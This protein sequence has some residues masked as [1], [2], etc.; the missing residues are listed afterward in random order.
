MKSLGVI[1]SSKRKLR[2]YKYLARS[3]S[4]DDDDDENMEMLADYLKLQDPTHGDPFY[5]EYEK[6]FNKLVDVI[7][8]EMDKEELVEKSKKRKKPEVKKE[9]ETVNHVYNIV[10]GV[11]SAFYAKSMKDAFDTGNWH[12]I[13]GLVVMDEVVKSAPKIRETVKK[14]FTRKEKKNVVDGE[15]DEN[16]MLQDDEDD[17]D[18][19]NDQPFKQLDKYMSWL[20]NADKSKNQPKP[21]EE[22]VVDGYEFLYRTLEDLGENERATAKNKILTL[23]HDEREKTKDPQYH[24]FLDR[25]LKMSEDIDDTVELKQSLSDM[26]DK[27]QRLEEIYHQSSARISDLEGKLDLAKHQLQKESKT[28]G[29]TKKLTEQLQRERDASSQ[30]EKQLKVERERLKLEQERNAEIIRERDERIAKLQQIFDDAVKK[31]QVSEK[32]ISELE[33]QAASLKRALELQKS[34]FN[35]LQTVAKQK[36]TEMHDKQQKELEEIVQQ[37]LAERTEREKS[38]RTTWLTAVKSATDAN[39]D[40]QMKLREEHMHDLRMLREAISTVQ[41]QTDAK[42]KEIDANLSLM[43]ARPPSEIEKRY[44]IEAAAHGITQGTLSELFLQLTHKTRELEILKESY[45]KALS[46]FKILSTSM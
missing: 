33:E 40:L 13:P 15:E 18:D 21:T 37:N 4:G 32:T 20:K 45:E 25:L 31:K 24:S 22:D 9:A 44:A 5:Q 2:K 7:G 28:A 6:P 43:Q 30:I 42:L 35:K 19:D 12:L 36:L 14:L 8:T 11:Y 3:L 16:T 17:E 26:R 41:K 23:I 29:K 34:K 27:R 39:K 46:T 10:K 1:P 38:M